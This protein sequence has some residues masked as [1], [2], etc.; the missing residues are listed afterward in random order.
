M[1]WSA[2]SVVGRNETSPDPMYGIA[3]TPGPPAHVAVMSH[4]GLA[5]MRQ[6][7]LRAP[8][9]LRDW[10]PARIPLVRTYGTPTSAAGGRA[11]SA[12]RWQPCALP[13]IW[14]RP[15]PPGV[16]DRGAD[17]DDLRAPIRVVGRPNRR[18]VVHEPMSDE[19]GRLFSLPATPLDHSSALTET[20]YAQTRTGLGQAR[21]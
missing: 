4:V 20:G 11:W 19:R 14:H 3:A 8:L 10:T 21:P 13:P 7:S 16:A 2:W 6:D 1:A 9:S 18:S 5:R 12:L 17:L 15:L